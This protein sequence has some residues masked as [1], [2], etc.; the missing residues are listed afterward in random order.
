VAELSLLEREAAETPALAARQFQALA[1]ELPGLVARIHA[2]PP[3]FTATIARGSS[4]H[5]AAVAGYLF[6]LRLH[7]A[8]ASLPPSLAS[9]Y[10]STL[11]LRDALVIAVSQSGASPD[12]CATAAMARAGGAFT[13]GL[14]NATRSPLSGVVDAELAIGAGFEQAVAATKS[15]VLSLTALVHLVAQLARDDALVDAVRTLP[16]A[17][18][19]CKSVDWAPVCAML[20]PAYGA[21]V[22]GRGPSLPVAREMALKLKEVC[23]IH[24]EALSAAELQ[25]G[26][27]AAASPELP[28]IVIAGDEASRP[29]VDAALARLAAAGAPSVLV[30]TRS[31]GGAGAT[32]RLPEAGDLLLQPV[33]AALAW[34]PLCAHLARLRGRDPDRP[35]HLEKITRTI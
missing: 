28:A 30:A 31:A 27:I 29:S 17:L 14:V 21:F 35:P 3:A 20:E 1:L 22:I 11:K 9:V 32:V 33:V 15:F 19:D 25:H 10:G 13:L 16:D 24:G 8:C 26:P 34:Y 7:L 12:L 18:D 5:A 4:D 2:R 23:G 6:G